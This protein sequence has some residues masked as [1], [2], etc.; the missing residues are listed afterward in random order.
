MSKQRKRS[1]RGL[2][3]PAREHA[4]HARTATFAM[5]KLSSEVAVKI[6]K[7]QCASAFDSFAAF[8][9]WTGVLET[10]LRSESPDRQV[11]DEQMLEEYSRTKQ[12]L[13][14]RCLIGSR[15]RTRR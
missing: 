6:G 5:R 11:M 1:R 12:K 13:A 4:Q 14:A 9:Y 15:R 2:G 7:G 3:L 8:A 10:E